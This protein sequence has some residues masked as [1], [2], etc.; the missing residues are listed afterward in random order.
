M[1]TLTLGLVLVLPLY[2][3]AQQTTPAP[4]PDKPIVKLP[5]KFSW[6]RTPEQNQTSKPS[7]LSILTI[8]VAKSGDLRKTVTAYSD[9]TSAS[10]WFTKNVFLTEV[11]GRVRI[12]DVDPVFPQTPIPTDLS[13]LAWVGE[14][15]YQKED[16]IDQK[17]AWYF[18]KKDTIPLNDG[19]DQ[20]STTLVKAW[21]DPTTRLPLAFHDGTVL[22]RYQFSPFEGDL[23]VPGN[24]LQEFKNF[25]ERNAK[26]QALR[27]RI[28]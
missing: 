28:P 17:A 16:K 2:A 5:D 3:F 15:S 26:D 12:F 25:Q 22:W 1:K 6:T 9:G 24:L 8:E 20:T 11:N 13:E 7:G 10:E 19:T 27:S 18:E 23:S 4:P 21:I 14:E